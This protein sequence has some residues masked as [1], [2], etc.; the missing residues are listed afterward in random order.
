MRQITTDLE[1]ELQKQI[2]LTA[3]VPVTIS[4]TEPGVAGLEID[5]VA[6]DSM[7]CSF[8]E[9]RLTVPSLMNAAPDKL[10][11]WGDGLC[12]RVTYLLENIGPL[13]CDEDAGELLIR[14]TTPQQLQNGAKYYEVILQA[15]ANGS[16]TLK[17]YEFE[18]GTPG[19][20]A[21]NIQLTHEVLFKLVDDLLDTIP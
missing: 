21:V 20:T 13:E 16:F 3:S 5:F 14:S 19:R 12:Q 17:R 6:I 8:V 1:F 9:L 10:K 2:G 15:N 4:A 7:S 18:K 11:T